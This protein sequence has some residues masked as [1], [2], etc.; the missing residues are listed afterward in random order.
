M[1]LVTCSASLFP[2]LNLIGT[3][4]KPLPAKAKGEDAN[5]LFL[6][7]LLARDALH[8]EQRRPWQ[9]GLLVV[10]VSHYLGGLESV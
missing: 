3:G 10:L 4:G 7:V 9:A 6:T 8:E 5:R 1:E 2:P